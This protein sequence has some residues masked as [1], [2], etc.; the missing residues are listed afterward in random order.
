MLDYCLAMRSGRVAEVR[1]ESPLGELLARPHH[2]AIAGHL[3]DNRR[4]SDRRTKPIATDY[5]SLLVVESRN[6]ETIDQADA[7]GA[8][9]AD[10]RFA[11]RGEV[12]LVQPTLVDTP[13]AA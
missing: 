3:G 12:G 11:Q 10:Q 5:R 9:D 2:Q 6:R 13:G 8:G 4:G 1:A 7:T